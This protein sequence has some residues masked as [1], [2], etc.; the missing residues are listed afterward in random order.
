MWMP[1]FRFVI[2]KPD[3][4]GIEMIRKLC[5]SARKLTNSH[6]AT[7]YAWV[8]FLLLTAG[9]L[10]GCGGMLA[11]REGQALMA[12]GKIEQ[13]LT[14]LAEAVQ[15]DPGNAEYRIVL[16]SHRLSITN[17][18]LSDAETA[19]R[20]THLPDAEKLYR[21]VLA[22][23]PVNIMASQGLEAIDRIRRHQV[24]LAEAAVLFRQGSPADLSSA[25]EKLRGILAEN[26]NFKPALLLK[27]RI[28][29]QCAKTLKPETRL[30]AIFRKPISLEF[31]DAPLKSV[32]EVISKISGLNFFYDQDIPS[33]LKTTIFARSSTIEDALRLVLATSQLEHKILNENSILIYPNTPQKLK[34]YQTLIVRGFYLTNADVKDVANSIKTL[35]K[36]KDV[37]IDERLG[38]VI[39]RDTPEA[40]RMAERIVNLQDMSD[41][42]VMLEVEIMEI[43]R[44]RLLELGVQ[45]PGQMSLSPLQV[46]GQPLTWLDL[47]QLTLA[48]TQVT[49]GGVTVNV[50]KEDQNGNILANPRIRVRNKEKAKIQIG[51]RV[52]VI[53]TTSTST[54]FVSESVNYVDVGLKLE[55]EPNIYLNN[56]VAIKINLE[57]SNLVREIVSA[58]GTLSYQIGTRG[59]STVL[60]LKDGETQ[61]LAGLINNE[62]R[63]TANKIPLLGELPIAG[64]L[65]G[66]QKD[67]NQRSEILLSITPRI[68]RA[69]QRPDILDAEFESG[70]ENS[71]GAPTLRLSTI[72][73]AVDIAANP[74]DSLPASLT[75]T[76]VDEEAAPTATTTTFTN[77]PLVLNWQAPGQVRVGESFDVVLRVK[78]E[79][80][81]R[82]MSVTLGFD[83]QVLQVVGV[84]E[85][86]FFRKM[87]GQTSFNYRQ[88]P[89]QGNVF[90]ALMRQNTGI[91]G[92]GALVTISFKATLSS[93]TPTRLQL[94]SAT[95]DPVSSVALPV[96][97]SL[98]VLP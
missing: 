93:D 13:G 33:A 85:G 69:I 43:T 82:N 27:A 25:S 94:L 66:S 83:P 64:R 48:T 67:D 88:D 24:V 61:I 1:N 49:I 74:S 9:M 68:V 86:N 89:V 29:E 55:V 77:A 91:D 54:G 4:P 92:E 81:L 60:Q 26:P 35:V 19:R 12:E 79:V 84:Q 28:D 18:M 30:A 53:T 5:F 71:I 96:E 59:A 56:E 17:R 51:D 90:A 16:A 80:A 50:K 38:I 87:G 6:R 97:Q 10:S 52:P 14:K 39:V 2:L 40:I 58:S 21:D 63:T 95:P 8:S 42:E 46:T 22:L 31:R 70:T 44:S 47:R 62:D 78:S 57:V 73:P 20:A 41:P 23:D 75:E 37:V 15:L 7:K 3:A 34:E 45:W 65:F 72:D 98:R 11:H 76:R 32:L 36:S